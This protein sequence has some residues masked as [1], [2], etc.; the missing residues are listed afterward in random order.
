MTKIFIPF[1]VFS[2]LKL[3]YSVLI[4]DEFAHGGETLVQQV[5]YSI[6]IGRQYW[7]IY[8]ILGM[9]LIAPLFWTKKDDK[10]NGLIMLII[11]YA[12]VCLIAIF[13]IPLPEWFQIDHI[14]N[15]LPYFVFGCVL[16][17]EKGSILRVLDQKKIKTLVPV[18]I[19]LI[20]SFLNTYIYGV[21]QEMG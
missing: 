1:V 16:R 12:V 8:T 7:F 20:V 5:R 13:N 15:Y 11:S 3:V 10:S 4:S 14:I 19:L 9:Y 21:S 6:F 2:V 17:Q 18:T